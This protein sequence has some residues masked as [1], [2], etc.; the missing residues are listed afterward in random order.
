[1]PADPSVVPQFDISDPR[2]ETEGVRLLTISSGALGGRGDV[3]LYVPDE[4]AGAAT[5]P[6][7]L[8]LHGV[9]GS[10]WSW[11]GQGGAHRTARRLA[12]SGAI[13]PMAIACPSDG[14]FRDGSG[15][16]DHAGGS[17]ATWIMHD[18][19]DCV[20]LVLDRSPATTPLF[21]SGLSMGG[22]GALRLGAVHAA[23]V[24]GISAHS[25]VTTLGDLDQFIRAPLPVDHADLNRLDAATAVIDAGAE[26]PPLRFDC[27][28][29]DQ[30]LES[31]RRLHSRLAAAGV[32]HAYE[33]H[34]GTHDWPY[35]ERHVEDSLRFFEA[36][37]RVTRA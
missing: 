1:M 21:L 2:F 31:N 5:L 28:T 14:L 32:P 17:F 13:R 19:V 8:L 36:V 11:F 6:I 35:W 10:H 12:A 34:P 22:Y 7:V 27:G 16:L 33:E 15:Y 18:V 37:L 4:A 25:A 20:R 9:Y 29:D 23:D 26:L 3:S 30:L 24:A